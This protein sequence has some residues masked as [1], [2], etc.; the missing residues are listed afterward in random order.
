M[1]L[2]LFVVS[3]KYCYTESVNVSCKTLKSLRC[4]YFINEYSLSTNAYGDDIGNVFTSL[5]VEGLSLIQ[6]DVSQGR[7]TSV[8]K[9]G[10]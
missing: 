8:W 4:F 3:S 7:D 10:G 5:V 1:F 6:L 2:I 9:H